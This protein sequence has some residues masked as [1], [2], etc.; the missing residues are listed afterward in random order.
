[1]LDVFENMKKSIDVLLAANAELGLE[2]VRLT[3]I[4]GDLETTVESQTHAIKALNQHVADQQQ[5][6]DRLRSLV[7]ELRQA[8]GG[9]GSG[10]MENGVA[11]ERL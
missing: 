4:K 5:L 11:D 8:S 7:E 9:K 6:I 2:I 1:M 3:T 10:H